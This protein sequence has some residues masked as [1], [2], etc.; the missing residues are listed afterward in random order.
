MSGTYIWL[1]CTDG[2]WVG[3]DDNR[4]Y[5]PK[6]ETLSAY[7]YYHRRLY[8]IEISFE[9]YLYP[10]IMNH[11]MDLKIWDRNNKIDQIMS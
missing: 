1:I 6:G 10:D 2:H 9:G 8:D 5:V 4:R 7:V 3:G 11:Y